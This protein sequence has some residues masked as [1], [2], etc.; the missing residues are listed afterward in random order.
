[1]VPCSKVRTTCTRK[2]ILDCL[3][4]VVLYVLLVMAEIC[5]SS[6]SMLAL[7]LEAGAHGVVVMT[8]LPFLLRRT[9]MGR[10]SL[11]LHLVSSSVMIEY[12]LGRVG[13]ISD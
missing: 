1:M 5:G 11:L 8:I 9:S 6:T 2:E 3:P 10:A 7:M 4:L 12:S 13:V